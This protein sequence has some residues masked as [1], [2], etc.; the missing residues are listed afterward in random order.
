MDTCCYRLVE[1]LWGGT[2]Q[3]TVCRSLPTPK[4]RRSGDGGT[5]QPL[6]Q[7]PAQRDPLATQVRLHQLLLLSSPQGQTLRTQERAA[8]QG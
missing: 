2:G 8:T 6:P 1:L 7:R 3:K 5:H 4:A